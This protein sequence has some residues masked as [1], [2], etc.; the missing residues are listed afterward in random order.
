MNES[1]MQRV[2][3]NLVE[4]VVFYDRQM[5]IRWANRAACDSVGLRLDEIVDKRCHELWACADKPCPD[6]PVARAL[7]TG[8]MH[9][10][11][12]TTPDGRAWFVRGHPR[13]D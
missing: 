10:V 12:K 8:R 9:E 2:F 13:T 1:E 3:D 4:H 5:N 6:C 11:E 7:A